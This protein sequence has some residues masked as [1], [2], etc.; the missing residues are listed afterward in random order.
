MKLI[1]IVKYI[2]QDTIEGYVEK[3]E[4]FDSWLLNH[5]KKRKEQGELEE[6]KSEFKLL[7][8]VKL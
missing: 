3:E 6:N 1:N 4:D 8:I 7:K 5:N 2:E